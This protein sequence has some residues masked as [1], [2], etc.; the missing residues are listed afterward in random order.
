ME[1]RQDQ[2][3]AAATPGR[4]RRFWRA[5]VSWWDNLVPDPQVRKGAA[6]GAVAA[7]ALV[8]AVLGASLHLGLG[9]D[10]LDAL[11]GAI[12]GLVVGGLVGLAGVLAVW[13]LEHLLRYFR[14]LTG[15]TGLACLVF[16]VFVLKRFRM[17]IPRTIALALALVAAQSILSGSLV[18]F[19][20]RLWGRS[21]LSK[22]VLTAALML[23]ALGFDGYFVW[24]LAN[25]GTS[26]HLRALEPGIN[27]P[28][29]AGALE[30]PDP[31]QPGNHEVLRLTYGSGTDNRPEFG[32]RATLIT[33][34]IDASLLVKGSEGWRMKVRHWLWGFDFEKFPVNGR[35]WYPEGPGPFPLVLIVHGNHN[36]VERSDPGYAYLG[37]HLASRG[38]ILVSVDE[39]FFNGS[40]VGGLDTENDGRGWMLLNHL[41]VWRRWNREQDNPFYGKVDMA[42]IGLIGH[43]R[44]GEAAAIAGAFNRLSH[45][46]DD[47]TLKFDFG[48]DI[49]AII[50]IAPS[51]G[52]YNPSDRPTSL[53]NVNYLVLQG[54][55]DSD[56][57]SFAGSRQLRRVEF[58]D[59]NYWFKASLYCYRCNHGQFNTVWGRTDFSWP[60]SL[61]LN[62]KPLLDGEE[63]RRLGKVFITSFLETT[64]SGRTE[65]LPV[66]RDH[67]RAA[68][69]LP[70]DYYITQFQDSTFRSVCDFEEDVDVT[71][72][73][74]SG[75]RIE[76]TH[77]AVWR[78]AEMGYRKRGS[79][80]NKAV[81]LGWRWEE[82]KAAENDEKNDEKEDTLQQPAYS[83]VLPEGL[84][85]R[86]NLN[87]ESLLAFSLADAGEKP[88][89]PDREEDS[90]ND[91][92]EAEVAEEKEEEVEEEEKPPLDLTLELESAGG[93]SV[94]APLS[95]F[96]PLVPALKSRF[97]KFANESAR[98]GKAWEP[99]LQTF[100][101]PF[102]ALLENAPD[103][104]L[105]DLKVI[106]FLFDQRP[107][108][109]LI[110]DNLGLVERRREERP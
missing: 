71:T 13:I 80:R 70:E 109:V 57:S 94:G 22:K 58:D 69:W 100:E 102:S 53:K 33:D 96:R 106:R 16:F 110:L 54:A 52:Q 89:E 26:E 42:H 103:F 77:L 95:R 39:N 19:R 66:F 32:E 3:A 50:A 31:S 48:F 62:L 107:E 25:D 18:F 40:W 88:P 90:D 28:L 86:W 15:W 30:E 108:G 87:R 9:S 76:G 75:G 44:G 49:R 56:V 64:L 83:I 37:E 73:S 1:N 91:Q 24:W 55:H 79:K 63:Q 34:S 98:Y 60:G 93:R 74:L 92:D 99:A 12:L 84:M 20:R 23:A 85:R 59:G 21:T 41:K 2:L 10:L 17:D 38:F 47:A 11:A 82:E 14:R 67:R 46:P 105:S 78:E 61:L 8:A 35:V 68:Q 51:D 27:R 104:K 29:Q 6:R 81:F 45:Y 4:W 101:I 65:Y 36:M 97:T 72:P 7:S 5:T 43:S